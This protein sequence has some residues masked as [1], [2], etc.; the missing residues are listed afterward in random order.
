LPSIPSNAE[1]AIANELLAH[2][3]PLRVRDLPGT[4]A[5]YLTHAHAVYGLLARG[6]STTQ[7]GRYLH[8]VES[9]EMQHPEL[10]SVD[11]SPLLAALRA[12][13]LDV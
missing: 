6:A 4:H 3:D 2:W 13:D 10:A 5:E 11:L 1:R 12:I 9:G 7:I 8:S